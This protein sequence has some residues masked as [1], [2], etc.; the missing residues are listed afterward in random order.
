MRKSTSDT[1]GER[2]ITENISAKAMEFLGML[3]IKTS[4]RKSCT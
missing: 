2:K 4:L 3:S 1:T